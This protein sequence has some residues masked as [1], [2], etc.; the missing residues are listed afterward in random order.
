MIQWKNLYSYV[1]IISY[2]EIIDNILKRHN[3][4][5]AKLC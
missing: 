4:H 3:T 1:K 2:R 5:Y